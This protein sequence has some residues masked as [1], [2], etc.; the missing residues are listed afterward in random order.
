MRWWLWIG[1][2]KRM[3]EVLSIM[4]CMNYWYLNFNHCSREQQPLKPMGKTAFWNWNNLTILRRTFPFD[5]MG[6]S[7][8]HVPVCKYEYGI[9]SHFYGKRVAKCKHSQCIV[10]RVT[11]LCRVHV[12]RGTRHMPGCDSALQ[13]GPALNHPLDWSTVSTWILCGNVG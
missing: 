12:N 6:Q 4:P 3:F 8:S 2:V 11:W 1:A 5:L 13:H 9:T 10:H 7:C